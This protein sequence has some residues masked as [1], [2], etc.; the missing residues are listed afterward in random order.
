MRRWPTVAA[1][2]KRLLV[3]RRPV[4]AS[5]VPAVSGVEPRW[6]LLLTE[7]IGYGMDIVRVPER[8]F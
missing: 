7:C 6:Q 8:F 2:V 3:V 4:P 5:E 1:A